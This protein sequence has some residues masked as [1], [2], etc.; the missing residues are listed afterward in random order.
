MKNKKYIFLVF[1]FVILFVFV[2]CLI[3]IGELKQNKEFDELEKYM[4]K[5]YEKDYLESYLG[6]R[7][8][9][10]F[11]IGSFEPLDFLPLNNDG[12]FVVRF[13]EKDSVKHLLKEL[14][15]SSLHGRL[16]L[17]IK[18]YKQK[19][20]VYIDG[21]RQ[22]EEE[23]CD[24]NNPNLVRFSRDTI[25]LLLNG[26]SKKWVHCY[27]SATISQENKY[28]DSLLVSSGLVVDKMAGMRIEK[29]RKR[30]VYDEQKR[31]V[32]IKSNIFVRKSIWDYLRLNFIFSELP[33]YGHVTEILDYKND[34][35]SFYQLRFSD[36]PIWDMKRTLDGFDYVY[37]KDNVDAK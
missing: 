17:R 31:I 11:Y 36:Y 30:F 2:V 10:D 6:F 14:Y 3:K 7:N 13:F 8:K 1:L 22:F 35:V 5:C 19:H 18:N 20:T 12:K 33:K 29:I 37:Y 4:E 9:E 32:K 23:S 34:S 25:S 24:L 27:L 28:E 16:D 26:S 21:F 15:V